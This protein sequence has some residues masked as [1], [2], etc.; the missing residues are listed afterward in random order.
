MIAKETLRLNTT[1]MFPLRLHRHY[2]GMSFSGE[3]KSKM[4]QSVPTLSHL[5][6][7]QAYIRLA[8]C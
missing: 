4:T 8:W 2:R 6:N 3:M 1:L 7:E 5:R